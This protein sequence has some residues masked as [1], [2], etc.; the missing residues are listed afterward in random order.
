MQTQRRL[1]PW[2]KRPLPRSV[3]QKPVDNLLDQQRL[4]TVCEEANC[5]NKAQ[6]FTH[7]TATFMI[8]GDTCTRACR[9]CSV[10]FGRPP[11]P[12]DPQE[13]ARLVH[14]ALAMRLEHVVITSVDRDDLPDGGSGHWAAVIRAVRQAM[15][16][17]VVEVLVPDFQGRPDQ[18]DT[19]LDAGPHVF[20]HNLEVVASL[21]RAIQPQKNYA[22]SLDVLR[23]AKQR[24][25]Q[26]T[27]KSGLM[28]GLGET[29]QELTGAMRDLRQA[30]VDMLTVGQYLR[31]EPGL[32]EVVRY[33]RPGEFA[34]I[35]AEALALGFGKVAAGPFV[36][37]S[38][39]AKEQFI[40]TA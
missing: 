39:N 40:G 37:S 7:G 4:V 24:N 19:V 20:N 29:R 11:A 9:F 1:P 35:K 25:P 5:P 33:Y 10:K 14:A 27:T 28:V 17:A 36:R 18:M 30:G 2:L 38:Y 34:E 6:C 23:F 12:P 15:P 31:P 22:R 13:P 3:G 8:L 21:Y 26:L 16:Q 32:A